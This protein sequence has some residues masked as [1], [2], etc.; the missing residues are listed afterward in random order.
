MGYFKP[1]YKAEIAVQIVC[2]DLDEIN[3]DISQY[4]DR[5]P[6]TDFPNISGL[7]GSNSDN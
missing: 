1:E 5:Q 3:H 2:H 4:L 7:N 6:S